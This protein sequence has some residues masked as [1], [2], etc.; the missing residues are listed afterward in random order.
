MLQEFAGQYGTSN[1]EVLAVCH[2]LFERDSTVNRVWHARRL[3]SKIVENNNTDEKAPISPYSSR[4][5]E[6]S[7]YNSNEDALPI[8]GS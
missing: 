8:Y 7:G 1:S 3:F 2:V 4:K 6:S 5:S